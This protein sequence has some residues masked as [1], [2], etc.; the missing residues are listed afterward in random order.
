MSVTSVAPN[1]SQQ[2]KISTAAEPRRPAA[3]APSAG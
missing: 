3:A 1:S 2:L